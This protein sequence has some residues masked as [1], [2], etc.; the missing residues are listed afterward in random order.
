M[1]VQKPMVM[2]PPAPHLC[3]ICAVDHADERPHN[4]QSFYYKYWFSLN[5]GRSPTWADAMAHKN[6]SVCGK[7]SV[8]RPGREATRG[9]L[10]PL[11]CQ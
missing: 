10:V 9:T 4:A 5:N 2:L 8:F 11:F 3:Q 6:L 7:P 1:Q